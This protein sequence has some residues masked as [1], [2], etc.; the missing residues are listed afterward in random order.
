MKSHTYSPQ[1]ASKNRPSLTRIGFELIPIPGD[2]HCLYRA[3]GLYLGEIPNS[4]R[5]IVANYLEQHLREFAPFFYQNEMSGLDLYEYLSAIAWGAEWASHIEIEALMCALNRPILIIGPDNRL[6][7]ANDRERFG[8]EPIFVYYNG[9]NHYDGLVVRR[10]MTIQSVL[11]NLLQQPTAA[12]QQSETQINEYCSSIQSDNTIIGIETVREDIPLLFRERS[13]YNTVHFFSQQQVQKPNEILPEEMWNH[14]FSFSDIHDLKELRSSCKLFNRVADNCQV[15]WKLELPQDPNSSRY[16]PHKDFH[17]QYSPLRE[18][19]DYFKFEDIKNTA[20]KSKEIRKFLIALSILFF[21]NLFCLAPA[22]VLVAWYRCAYLALYCSRSELLLALLS[23]VPGVCFS[24]CFC[25]FF[26]DSCK[27]DLAQ[28]KMRILKSK[29]LYVDEQIKAV[30]RRGIE[31]AFS[32]PEDLFLSEGKF[33]M[34]SFLFNKEKK[35]AIK[36]LKMIDEKCKNSTLLDYVSEQIAHLSSAERENIC[37][38]LPEP[39]A[40]IRLSRKEIKILFYEMVILFYGLM[41]VEKCNELLNVLAQDR[42]ALEYFREII[43]SGLP[44]QAFTASEHYRDIGL[45]HQFPNYVAQ[46]PNYRRL[47][48]ISGAINSFILLELLGNP[49]KIPI[50]A[51]TYYNIV[52]NHIPIHYFPQLIY[53]AILSLM[54]E[55]LNTLA[56]CNWDWLYGMENTNRCIN[57][58]LWPL[59]LFTLARLPERQFPAESSLETVLRS[60]IRQINLEILLGHEGLK[61]ISN[62]KEIYR[63]VLLML[64]ENRPIT[65]QALLQVKKFRDFLNSF[66]DPAIQTLLQSEELEPPPQRLSMS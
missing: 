23:D 5:R 52:L 59:A 16:W 51:V 21:I 4:L 54:P 35:A 60:S 27:T 33:K 37:D 14:I 8:R 38:N 34:Y 55:Q 22:P 26:I 28:Y 48:L 20:E 32:W 25:L 56:N 29:I 12:T 63:T 47:L 15:F 6:I 62:Y 17:L 61:R 57:N 49:D 31:K 43:E 7:N 9:R 41:G 19:L 42:K 3:V 30:F 11:N 65:F 53:H 58:F 45:P 44:L 1:G 50:Q 66:D 18:I 40:N 36:I 2:G 39:A 64:A 10:G 46:F 13:N 24:L